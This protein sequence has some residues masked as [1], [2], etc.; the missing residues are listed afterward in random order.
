MELNLK[1]FHTALKTVI[2]AVEKMPDANG[3]H[4]IVFSKDRIKAFNG[5]LGIEYSMMHG[6]AGTVDGYVLL[7]VIAS[8]R[9]NDLTLTQTD[10]SIELVAGKTKATIPLLDF[11]IGRY[12]SDCTDV[13]YQ[14][15]KTPDNFNKLLKAGVLPDADDNII[16]GVYVSGCDI[17]STNT[18][19]LYYAKFDGQLDPFVLPKK[20]VDAVCKHKINQISE[21]KAFV[22]CR[23]QGLMVYGRK[24]LANEYPSEMLLGAVADYIEGEP[25]V[26]GAIPKGFKGMS[27]LGKTIGEGHIYIE[28]TDKSMEVT[29]ESEGNKIVDTYDDT[30]T[31]LNETEITVDSSFLAHSLK[32]A[33]IESLK[34]GDGF[35]ERIALM[36]ANEEQLYV[37]GHVNN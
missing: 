23:T 14:W 34:I 26:E 2:P 35:N 16:N 9:G 36:L 21:N 11:P 25:I 10:S 17:V 18:S 4:C 12:I 1:E 19:V 15:K 7:R 6:L 30:F 22:F 8:M 28:T 31:T 29:I 37:I 32:S 24:Q 3:H 20:V 5:W 33:N 13:D 27:N